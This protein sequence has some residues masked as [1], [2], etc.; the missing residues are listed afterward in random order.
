MTVLPRTRRRLIS[1][2][3][4]GSFMQVSRGSGHPAPD[5]VCGT[6][7]EQ[8]PRF[9]VWPYA[10]RAHVYPD[11]LS[12]SART[13]PPVTGRARADAPADRPISP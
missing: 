11:S 7:A 4:R 10:G 8:R 9:T 5:P 13:R 2:Q 1:T 12:T 6:H 3:G